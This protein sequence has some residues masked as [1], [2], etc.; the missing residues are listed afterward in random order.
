MVQ[1]N[2]DDKFAD[3]MDYVDL[4]ESDLENF[5]TFRDA[6]NRKDTERKM[7]NLT[8]TL[9]E[10]SKLKDIVFKNIRDKQF[11]NKRIILNRVDLLFELVENSKHIIT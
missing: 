4:N 7:G 9:E 11:L 3:V 6:V 2:I 1:G 5:E 10:K 8:K